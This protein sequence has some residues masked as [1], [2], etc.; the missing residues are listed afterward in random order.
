MSAK[1]QLY[2]ML[3]LAALVLVALLSRGHSSSDSSSSRLG[4]G[5]KIIYN[6]DAP[7]YVLPAQALDS[8][9]IPFANHS[10]AKPFQSYL[11]QTL[12][13]AH[14]KDLFESINATVGTL[15][16]RGEAHVTVITPP[17]FDRVLGPAGVTIEEIEAI[18][19]RSDIQKARLVPV[20]LGRFVG[21]LPNPVSDDDS[22]DFAVYSLVV[23]DSYDELTNIRRE[24][25]KLFRKKGGQGA[26]FQPEGFWPHV[27]IGFDRRDLFVED[28]LYKG[29]NFCY[30]PIRVS[31]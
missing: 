3:A 12:D 11:Q 4:S 26:L 5:G 18:A 16:S 30:A 24:V 20:C 10:T 19:L 7:T 31:K 2:A 15:Q 8:S 29:S 27:T 9:R 25:F 1:P 28:G 6:P 17:E 23:A 13:F 14:F 21:K 22:G